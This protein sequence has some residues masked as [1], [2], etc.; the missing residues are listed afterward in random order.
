MS[1][2]FSGARPATM[3]MMRAV[4]EATGW[5]LSDQ[6][7]HLEHYGSRL[8]LVMESQFVAEELPQGRH[9]VRCENCGVLNSAGQSRVDPSVWFV[10]MECWNCEETLEFAN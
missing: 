5:K 3:P 7:N 9:S 6:V 4:E 1:N 2:I 10:E 8:R